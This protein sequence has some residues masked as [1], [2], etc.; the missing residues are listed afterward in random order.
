MDPQKIK[1]TYQ[2]LQS[3]DERLTYRVR[4][5]GGSLTRPSSDQL[6]EKMRDLANFTVELKEIVDDLIVGI[7]ARPSSGPGSSTS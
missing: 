5:R 7:A 6:E 3:L 2:R 1:E 4:P